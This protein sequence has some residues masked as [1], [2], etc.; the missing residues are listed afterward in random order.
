M[1]CEHESRGACWLFVDVARRCLGQGVGFDL[2]SF[3]DRARAHRID[4]DRRGTNY[5]DHRGGID[6]RP[7]QVDPVSARSLEIRLDGLWT[8]NSLRVDRH[9]ASDGEQGPRKPVLG[10]ED[11]SLRHHRLGVHPGILLG[12]ELRIFEDTWCEHRTFDH[13]AFQADDDHHEPDGAEEGTVQ[14][15]RSEEH[16]HVGHLRLKKLGCDLSW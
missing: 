11:F 9:D 8:S 2:D 16:V 6:D 14:A 10:L 4:S 15:S 3:V 5:L 1:H 13:Q 12:G 7:E